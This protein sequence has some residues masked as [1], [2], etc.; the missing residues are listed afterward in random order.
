M[1]QTKLFTPIRLRELSARNRI[2]LSPMC[3]YQAVDGFVTDWH[4]VHYGRF[5]TGGIG[6]ALLESTAVVPEGRITHGCTGIWSDGQVDGLA[7]IAE[8]YRQNGVLSGLQL[9]HAGRRGSCRRPWDGAQPLTAGDDEQPYDLVAPS[10]VAEEAGSPCPRALTLAEIDDLVDA[11]RTATQRSLAAG[12][13]FVEVH[14]G[15]GYLLHQFLSGT[16]NRRSD[17]YGGS[18][19]N[20]MRLPLRVS[21]AVREMWPQDKPVFFRMSATDYVEGSFGIDDAVMLAAKLKKLGIDVIDCSTGGMTGPSST[22]RVWPGHQVEYAARI[23]AETGSP[24]VAVGA[25]IEPEHAEQIL[26]SGA[27]DIIALG[28]QLLAEPHWGYRAA[29]ALGHSDPSSVLPEYYGFYMR[30]RENALR[31]RPEN[32]PALTDGTHELRWIRR[33]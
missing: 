26:Q 32:E 3:Q 4:H 24:T 5:A 14:G 28:R 17:I 10:E 20:R 27:A 2:M 25:L 7:R 19:E 33:A 1:T 21:K 16:A 12:F 6:T 31:P 22:M 15:H 30:R 9:A 8:R 13:D 23:R 18:L 29:L 11:Y